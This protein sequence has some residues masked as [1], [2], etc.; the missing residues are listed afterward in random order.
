MAYSSNNDEK[1]F[2]GYAYN[3]GQLDLRKPCMTT[4]LYMVSLLLI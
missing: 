3:A 1:G 4:Y 2:Y